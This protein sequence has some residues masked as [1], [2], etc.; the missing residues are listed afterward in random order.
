M[1]TL[2]IL[3]VG[4]LSVGCLTP[5]QKQ[6][7]ISAS[8]WPLISTIGV[9]T[10][11]IFLYLY[12]VNRSDSKARREAEEEGDSEDRKE[13]ET[14]VLLRG[15]KKEIENTKKEVAWLSIFLVKIP[16]FICCVYIFHLINECNKSNKQTQNSP[17]TIDT[18]DKNPYKE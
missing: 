17:E 8:M 10:F 7:L 9:I 11:I 2:I 18:I 14:V 1:R 13:E 3:V 6:P 15:I 16:L 12:L 5:E 4:L